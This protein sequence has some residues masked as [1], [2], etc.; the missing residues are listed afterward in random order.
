VWAAAAACGM[1]LFHAVVGLSVIPVGLA[2]LAVAWAARR[3]ATWL[4]PPGRIVALGLA[5]LAGALLAGPYTLAIVRGWPAGKSGLHHSYL[6]VDPLLLWTLVSALAVTLWVA[7]RPLRDAFAGRHSGAALLA[8]FAAGMA[9]FASVVS[10]PLGNSIKFVYQVFVPLA[11][12][13][14]VALFDELAAWTR[15]LGRPLARLLLALV[16]LGAPAL[17]VAGYLADTEGRRSPQMSPGPAERALD[18]WV[19]RET[20]ANA[21]FV[22]AG[23][24]DLLMVQA[25]RQLLL[26]ST[27]GT[28]RA[29]FPRDQVEARRA[30]MADLYGPLAEA[31]R[32]VRRLAGLGRPAYVLVRDADAA[33]GTTSARPLE[34]RPDLFQRVYDRDGLA[35]YRVRP[36]ADQR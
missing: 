7:R 36:A 22:D 3:R 23:Y 4:P 21:V 28:E 32:D 5:T 8:L 20:P 1:L 34:R 35:L 16:F 18:D 10:L 26:G 2:V 19:R 9:A 17:T 15:R 27:Q 29:A 30:V 33:A 25:R 13:G 14:G 24:R 31:G 12:L 11:A 6:A